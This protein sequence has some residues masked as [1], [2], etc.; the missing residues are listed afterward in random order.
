MKA[1][2]YKHNYDMNIK[3][4]ISNDD[5]SLLYSFKTRKLLPYQQ[6]S[7]PPEECVI[8]LPKELYIELAHTI[9]A[10]KSV[11]EK[12]KSFLTGKLEATTNHLEDMRKLVFKNKVPK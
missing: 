4:L 8:S 6:D 2:I 12:E 10:D 7:E 9:Q 5:T 11:P 1:I 3:I